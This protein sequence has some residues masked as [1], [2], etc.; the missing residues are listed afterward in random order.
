MSD[1]QL[2]KNGKSGQVSQNNLKGGVK[3]EQIKDKKLQ[4]L[5]D[6]ADKN[7]DGVL[8]QSEVDALLKGLNTDSDDTITGK[9]AKQYLKD[10]KNN[11]AEL[12]QL[13]QEDVFALLKELSQAGENIE[14]AQTTE[15]ENGEQTIYVTYKDGTQETLFPDKSKEI[16]TEKDGVKTT[17]RYDKDNKLIKETVVTD[18]ETTETEYAQDGTPTL[19]TI[20]SKDGQVKTIQYE[21]GKPKSSEIKKGITTE[22]YT[23]DD[24]GNE[25]I[26]SKVENEGIPAK[27]SRTQYT[28]NEDGSI[29]TVTTQAG[30]KTTTITNGDNSTSTIENE[31]GSTT[32][33]TK[34]PD[35]T[36]TTTTTKDGTTTVT[37]EVPGKIITVTTLQDKTSTEVVKTDD[38]TETT[39]KFNANGKR[40]SQQITKDGQT[41]NVE[42]D[43]KGN[44]Y[45]IVQNAETPGSIA[46]KFGCKT[47]TLLG[48]NRH[49][50][51]ELGNNY[52]E[53]GKRIRVP[54]E[55]NADDK[56][57]I[58][59]KDSKGA[60]SDYVTSGGAAR[61]AQVNREVAERKDIEWTEKNKNTF[62]EIARGLFKAEG[63]ENPSNLQLSARIK[64]LKKD[65]PNLQDGQL[66]GKKI[67]AGVGKG[68]YDHVVEQQEKREAAAAA[69]EHTKV[70]KQSAKQIVAELKAAIDGRND[71]KKIQAAIARIDDPE[72]LAEV[73]RLLT[74]M[75]YKSTD[76]Y[77][78]IERF[79]YEENNHSI[80]HTYNS[81]DYLE[82]TVQKWINNGTLTGT[83]A[84][85]AQARMACR[86]I[87]DGGD[88]FG[89]D[90]NKIKKGVRWIKCPKPTGDKA[91]DNANARAVY[92]KANAI[93]AKHNTFYGLGSPSK[94]LVDY[95]EGEMWD[96]EVKYLKGIL[97]EDNAIHGKEKTDA[98]TDLLREAVE[99]GGTDIES[100]KQAL[101]GI[102]SPEDMKAVEEKLKAYCKQKGIKLQINGQSYLQAILY[103]ECDTFAGLHT[104]HKE[105]RKFNEMLIAQ[106]AYTPE[107]ATRLKAE[108]AAL[109]VLEGDFTNIKDALSQIKDPK[110]LAKMNELLGTK[111][112]NGLDGFLKSKVSNQTHRDLLKAELAAHKLLSD[113]DATAVAFRLVQNSD[114]DTRAKGL[115][116]IRTNAQAQAVDKMLKAKGSSLAKV[117]EQFNKEKAEYKK[118]AA[119]W[120]GL[121][122][123]LS[124]LGG[125]A[126]AEH[127]SDEYREN[128]DVSDNLYVEADTALNLTP[129]QKQAYS[130]TVKAFEDQLEK[131]KQDYQDTLDSQ[132]VISG[133]INEFCSIYNIG[134][135]RDEIEARIEHDTETLRLLKMASEGKLQKLVNGK[136]VNVSFEEVFNERASAVVS[137]NG[138][139]AVKNK[140][141]TTF[142]AEKAEKVA[143]Q[144]ERLAAMDVAKDYIAQTWEELGSALNSNNEKELSTA[145]YSSLN[146][147]SQM[148]GQKLSLD[149]FGYKL[150]NGVICDKNGQPVSLG[151]LQNL[152]NQL[153][154]GLS[155]ISKELLGTEIPMNSSNDSVTKL[156]D[157]GY[158]KKLDEFK[159]EYKEAFGQECPDEMIDSYRTTIETGVMIANVGVAIG[160]VIAAPFTGGGSLAVFCAAAGSTLVMQGLEQS[161]DADGW[162]NSEWTSTTAD[163]CWNGALAVVGMRVGMV[164]DKAVGGGYKIAA[165]IIAKQ[166]KTI[167]AL[168]PNISPSRLKVVSTIVARAEA[169]FGEVSSDVLQD[170][171]Q[172]YCMEGE[173]NPETFA[174]NLAMSLAGNTA[175]HVHG[176]FGDIRHGST[177]TNV[178]ANPSSG[179]SKIDRATDWVKDELGIGKNKKLLNSVDKT[180]QIEI[181]SGIKNADG[182]SMYTA[183]EITNIVNNLKTDIPANTLY[184]LLENSA[185]SKDSLNQLLDNIDTPEKARVLSVLVEADKVSVNGTEFKAGGKY[186]LD[187]FDI[188]DIMKTAET[189]NIQD[190][191]KFVKDLMDIDPDQYLITTNPNFT[192]RSLLEQVDTEA[193]KDALMA[194]FETAKTK[195]LKEIPLGECKF[196]NIKTPE[197]VALYKKYIDKHL[198][199]IEKDGNQRLEYTVLGM[200]NY[201]YGTL[202]TKPE[203]AKVKRELLES[204]YQGNSSIEEI[205]N[206]LSIVRSKT[207]GL[208]GIEKILVDNSIA[209]HN[210]PVDAEALATIKIENDYQKQAFEKLLNARDGKIEALYTNEMLGHITDEKSLA[211]FNKLVDGGYD[212]QTI[213]AS[214]KK[215]S[216][217]TSGLEALDA[218]KMR[219]SE[220]VNQALDNLPSAVKAYKKNLQLF[221]Q[222]NPK[223]FMKM[224]D[225]GL[226]DLIEQGKVDKS[227][228]ENVD[229]NTFLSN[230]TLNEIRRIKNNEPY[231]KTL[232]ST[233]DI[234]KVANGNV[235]EINGKMY[236]N[237]NGN[238]V[239][240]NLSKEKFE[241]LFPP[242]ESVTFHQRSL[243]DCWFVTSIDN[244]MDKPAGRVA[245]YKLFKQ[246]GNDIIVQFPNETRSITFPDGKVLDAQGK[247]IN[248]RSAD[249]SVPGI[250]MIEQAFAVHRNGK[251]DTTSM[252][253][254]IMAHSADVQGLMKELKG[255]WQYEVNNAILGHN[256]KHLNSY[257][258]IS[259]RQDMRECIQQFANDENTLLYFTTKP[260]GAGSTEKAIA[261][262][263]DLYS[264][265]AYA[266]KGYDP[267]TD[268]VYIT[269]PWHTGVVT[270]V[271]MSEFLKHIDAVGYSKLDAP[272]TAGTATT[273]STPTKAAGK[274]ATADAPAANSGAQTVSVLDDLETKYIPKSTKFP[275]ATTDVLNGLAERIKNGE[276][277]SREM[278]DAVINDVSAQTGI[279]VIDLKRDY[280][281][282]Q[283]ILRDDWQSLD[284]AFKKSEAEVAQKISDGKSIARSIEAFREKRGLLSE[285]EVQAKA[286]AELKA[287]Q[288]AELK[289]QREAAQEAERKAQAA[290]A[291]QARLRAEQQA[292]QEILDRCSDKF[293]EVAAEKSFR[294]ADTD[295]KLMQLMENYDLEM[296]PAT[297]NDTEIYRKIHEAGISNDADVDIA[298]DMIKKRFH[299]DVI[300]HEAKVVDLQRKY[301]FTSK[302]SITNAETVIADLK[303][304]HAAGEKITADDIDNGIDNLQDFDHRDVAR[305]KA[306][307]MDDPEIA[308]AMHLDVYNNPKYADFKHGI[309]TAMDILDRIKKDVKNGETLSLELVQRNIDQF[310]TV[311][312]AN[313]YYVSSESLWILQDVLR[314]DP[315]LS[316]LCKDFVED[317]IQGG[318]EPTIKNADAPQAG[319]TSDSA[320]A[321]KESA[322]P[323]ANYGYSAVS[324]NEITTGRMQKGVDFVLNNDRFPTFEL[325]GGEII[326]LNSPQYAKMVRSL[327]EGQQIT[328]GREGDIPTSRQNMA[329]SRNHLAIYKENG[330]LK[331]RDIS[332]NGTNV[333]VDASN[334]S[335]AKL[336]N[337]TMQQNQAYTLDANKL[338]KV[339]LANRV[340]VDLS[341]YKN[342]I[343][344]LQEGQFLTVGRE[345][346]IRVGDSYVSGQH[347]IIYKADGQL[348]IKDVSTNGTTV[349]LKRGGLLSRL[350]NKVNNLTTTS[351]TPQETAVL[352][353]FKGNRLIAQAMTDPAQAKQVAK[354]LEKILNDPKIVPAEINSIINKGYMVGNEG[355]IKGTLD[356]NIMNDIARL[357]VEG[358][359]IK[360]FKGNTSLQ[361]VF[362]NTPTGEVANVNGQLY[363]NNGRFMEHVNM[364]EKTF[365]KLFPPV[366]RFST[367]QGSIGTCYLVSSLERLYSSP[368]GRAQIYRLIG[369][370]AN[371]IYTRCYNGG[372]K[373]DYFRR[374]DRF[375]KHIQDEGGLA[376]IEQGYCKNTARSAQQ[377]NPRE[378]HIMDLNDGGWS[379][380]AMYGLIGVKPHVTYTPQDMVNYIRNYA[381]NDRFIIN[382]ATKGGNG[383]SDRNA[384]NQ[385]YN[386]YARHEYSIKGYDQA[387]D[388]VL[389]S[390]PWHSGCIVKIPVTEFVNYFKEVSLFSLT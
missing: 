100:L 310:D 311:L 11:N 101:K 287:R 253:T 368:S 258:H 360:S 197:D 384:L 167:K 307:I 122:P 158:E 169:T 199:M 229:N 118:K 357:A 282:A 261:K 130:M 21:N 260:K 83:E 188:I 12:K 293:P 123:A 329:V 1:I 278:L 194:L 103:D 259:G 305:M 72:E 251:Y 182:T 136:P 85:N 144:G 299:S 316:P 189:S 203:L 364:S 69:Q 236:V 377:F 247:Q 306:M 362:A 249:A 223:R 237:D 264:N 304:R 67:R 40:L 338:P 10:A 301:K 300:A 93:I 234:S 15:G 119:F 266:I 161:T 148:S 115:A 319:K 124:L 336:E 25:V 332:S 57:I 190:Y 102:D 217:D 228:L 162:T 81:S 353:K 49:E 7:K 350:K 275:Q 146:K 95:C 371:G 56:R 380:E 82:Q 315:E 117:Y 5:F 342:Q 166:E 222:A 139:T 9:E 309:P 205:D 111:N 321:P 175:G 180:Q 324:A 202:D 150:Q 129:E 365:R 369:E 279:S 61:E 181:L 20:K 66:I 286:D 297:F 225:S 226:F 359:Y 70:Q 75:G 107:Q 216:L 276:I 113:T 164:A 178:D 138:A 290:A 63:I 252:T 26:Q 366:T 295:I 281:R 201:R 198:K 170:L 94:N 381:N 224:V 92:A 35:K 195:K 240:L 269:N 90:C 42:Y 104:D 303:A 348:K 98:I 105:I 17:K 320:V 77:S 352:N 376:I 335:T 221:A 200:F 154:Q 347:L 239:E 135:T 109:Q 288:E 141:A 37:T 187:A 385:E 74:S 31:D 372:G 192:I 358:D 38:G 323:E 291:E 344:S 13:K 34:E 346:D 337:G 24:E 185:K 65:N 340:T 265:H 245:L 46:Q 378:T 209:T 284:Y 79:I 274:G 176:A 341:N 361:T 116:A 97:A 165:N 345:G 375:N 373:K 339:N 272:A 134:T 55:L 232:S 238:A 68:L 317:I 354:R 207:N 212:A 254:D 127:I 19:Q 159:Q 343:N 16:T 78:P 231:V 208:D 106:G 215:G 22:N 73:N 183:D 18:T 370:D 313:N 114:F 30:S 60:A 334:T 386:L 389:V 8:D 121:A 294:E 53:V 151:E 132:G 155:D 58:R 174:M 168:A 153:K 64:D 2:N 45:I 71:L 210:V 243:G 184:S 47:S 137:A 382:A 99:G 292:R 314:N 29:T 248:G 230:R 112:Y 270:E 327:Q 235:A 255:G 87:F 3:K 289:A 91:K 302:D 277:P 62:E 160:A 76:I 4:L 110:V 218:K 333:R 172:T 43:G 143:K 80:V 227:I 196:E 383:L 120:D 355:V 351:L 128:T 219:G 257:M 156:L 214:L 149:A 285:T 89:T 177:H 27:E 233:A 220:R 387:T 88:G 328:I 142:S 213:L 326:D 186:K 388:C 33:I 250:Q 140:P 318:F 356:P 157:K 267:E 191:T 171:L 325:P 256:D 330:Q 59:R 331:V 163:A 273:H 349:E 86:V 263:Y 44:T 298:F 50:R 241:E 147:I 133:A 6:A 126:I 54:G 131:M 262:E 296:T 193:Q 125:S 367:H 283:R 23:Y 268:M 36:V 363:V 379:E 145:I 211:Y 204:L 390:N 28:Y 152:A 52:F 84:N 312:R 322:A 41:Y 48:M 206:M 32:V 374:W 179:K 39:T 246:D 51:D 244:Y 280:A 242:L 308:K 14:K 173:F 108:Q 271:P 96:S